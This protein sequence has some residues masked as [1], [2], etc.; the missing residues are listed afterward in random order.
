MKTTTKRGP[1]K[2]NVLELARTLGGVSG[3]PPAYPAPPPIVCPLGPM[4]VP[5][6]GGILPSDPIR[7]QD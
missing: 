1:R 4:P 6:P 5:S 2:L 7:I 3:L